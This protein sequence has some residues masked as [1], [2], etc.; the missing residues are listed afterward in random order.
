MQAGLRAGLID[1]A[2][3]HICGPVP[4]HGPFAIGH[5][6]IG[7]VVA[8]GSHVQSLEVGDKVVVP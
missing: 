2:V 5:E 6:A 8:V 1:P 7:E 4:F 3:G